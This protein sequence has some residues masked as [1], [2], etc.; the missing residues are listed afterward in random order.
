M[1]VITRTEGQDVVLTRGGEEIRLR[2][3]E[4]RRGGQARVGVVAGEN[5]KIHRDDTPQRL[6][7]PH[8]PVLEE[9]L[10]P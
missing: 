2:L 4:V 10:D 5:W 1:L 7:G 9:P 6:P 8:A 3:I